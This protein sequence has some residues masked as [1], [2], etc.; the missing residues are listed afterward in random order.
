[1]R[2]TAR[3]GDLPVFLQ[4]LVNCRE[5]I[6]ALREN[7]EEE[8]RRLWVPGFGGVGVERQCSTPSAWGRN[9]QRNYCAVTASADRPSPTPTAL[10]HGWSVQY[11]DSACPIARLTTDLL[12][13]S[14]RPGP[15]A[16]QDGYGLNSWISVLFSVPFGCLLFLSFHLKNMCISISLWGLF[17]QYFVYLLILFTL[18]IHRVVFELF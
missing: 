1:M 6:S 8:R 12:S 3:C 14:Y 2:Q 17:L 9:W 7:E 18:F 11:R 15:K 5:I 10:G 13:V 4:S 16:M